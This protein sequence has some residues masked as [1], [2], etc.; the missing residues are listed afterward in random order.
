ML[1][2][3]PQIFMPDMKEPLF[4]A[5]DL[6]PYLQAPDRDRRPIFPA[7]YEEYLS[8]FEGARADQRVGE[9]SSGYL[10]SRLAAGAIAQAQ[11]AARIIA[12]LRDP[13]SLLRSLHLQRL[14]EHVETEQDLERAL[15][16]EDAR[17]KGREIPARLE[18]AQMLMYSDFIHYTEQLRRYEA[19]FPRKQ[20]LV[21]I[22][23]DY[24][25]DNQ[26]TVREVLRFL[27]VD[28][29]AAVS[30]SQANPTVTVR[31]RRL[32]RMVRRAHAGQGAV[33]GP[34]NSLV[35]TLTSPQVRQQVLYPFRNRLLYRDPPA[36]DQAFML[37][38]RRRYQPEVVALSEHL[39]R[40]LVALWGYD[41]LA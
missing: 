10:R 21:L 35:K 41:K 26:A 8:L 7:T 1:R 25:R 23:D 28:D 5:S 15:S 27:E 30:S 6:R 19:V 24:R 14:Q 20:V 38:L 12:I 37:E 40:D 32:E 17:R 3:H 33:W 11:P 4:F 16:L 13:A 34:V 18:Q 22:Y 29:T 9:A 36:T 39:G 31:S 2:S